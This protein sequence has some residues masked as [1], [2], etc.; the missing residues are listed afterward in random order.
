[1]RKTLAASLTKDDYLIHADMFNTNNFK[2]NAKV[3]NCGLG[4]SNALNIASGIASKNNNVYIYGV[5]GFIIH[6]FEQ[7]KFSV[8]NFGSKTGK[9]IIVNAGKIGY[10]GLGNGHVLDDDLDIMNI[11]KIKSYTPETLEEFKSILE[12]LKSIT[13]GIYYI[14]LGR[15][16]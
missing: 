5:C 3:I 14:Q 6:R 7:L 9:I 4:E 16:Y 10:S 11:L 8:R 12:E 2:T 1:M 13:T 15:D